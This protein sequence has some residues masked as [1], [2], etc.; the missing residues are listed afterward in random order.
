MVRC[1]AFDGSGRVGECGAFYRPRHPERT[2]FYRL[3]EDHFEAFAATHEE[4]YEREDGPLRPVVRR[5]VEAYLDCGRPESGFARVRCPSCGGEQFVAFSCATRNFCG[6]CQQKRAELLAEKL[7]EEILA[8]VPHRHAVFTVPRAL[9]KLFLRD[10]SLL[11]VLARCA[12]ETVQRVWRAALGRRDGAAGIVASIQTFGSQANWHPHIHALVTDGL[13]L[14]DGTWVAGPRYEEDLERALTETFRR[15]VLDTLVREASLSEVFAATLG[16][17]RHGGG[18]SVYARHLILAQEPR[19]LEHMARYAV[20]PPVAVDRVN[21]SS[22]GRVLLS[23]PPD[24]RTGATLLVLDPLE[25]IRR[26]TNQI[27]DP[28]SH[29]VRYYGAYANRARKLYRRSADDDPAAT[30]MEREEADPATLP[31]RRSWA[32]LLKKVF[33]V[34]L[35][36]PRCGTALVVVSFVQDPEVVDRILRHVRDEKVEQLFE[37]RGPPAA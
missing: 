22:D 20:R 7:R 24:P 14:R 9:R 18:F 26:L 6:S 15:L 4:R 21:V 13:F 10:R 12:A 34:E 23:I 30:A 3:I 35:V 32:R 36:C 33:E 17:W 5:V 28:R 37:A 11:G 8:D 1:V 31:R 19:R 2:T 25:W 29:M 27:P 16:T